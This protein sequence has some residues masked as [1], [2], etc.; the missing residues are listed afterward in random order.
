VRQGSKWLGVCGGVLGIALALTPLTA[1]SASK[2]KGSAPHSAMCKTVKAE[3]SGSTAASSG[4]VKAME[5]GNF[6]TAKQSML[7]LYNQDLGQV[8]KAL[9]VIKTAPPKVQAAFKNLLSYVKQFRNAIQNA[10]SLQGM[11]TA[12]STLGKN[13]QLQADGTTIANWYTSVCGGT[14]VSPTTV[15]VP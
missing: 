4:L 8:Q 3:E 10:S 7:K 12:F 9:A 1:A 13:T 6:A 5:S 11:I 2:V 14:L 15:S